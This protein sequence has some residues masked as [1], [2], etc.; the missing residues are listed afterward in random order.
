MVNI[1]CRH[2]KN[3][4]FYDHVSL[5]K[6]FTPKNINHQKVGSMIK[7]IFFTTSSDQYNHLSGSI[8]IGRS[9]IQQFKNDRIF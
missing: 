1:L 9:L 4:Q 3:I 5:H 2:S 8:V 7:I 6:K